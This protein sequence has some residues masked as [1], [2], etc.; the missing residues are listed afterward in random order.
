[1]LL[2]PSHI[3]AVATQLTFDLFRDYVN[4]LIREDE[5]AE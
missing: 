2:L 5:A 3:E 1:M 4:G